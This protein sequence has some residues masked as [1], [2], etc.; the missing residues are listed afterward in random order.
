[1]A[2]GWVRGGPSQAVAHIVRLESEP[3]YKKSFGKIREIPWRLG[4]KG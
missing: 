3:R 1:M 2:D 4:I